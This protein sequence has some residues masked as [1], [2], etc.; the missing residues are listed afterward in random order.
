[1]KR[2]TVLALLCTAVLH[3]AYTQ[4]FELSGGG[5]TILFDTFHETLKHRIMLPE[6]YRG[7][8]NLGQ[9]S[10][11]A[12]FE[13]SLQLTG[14]NSNAGG[15][16]LAGSRPGAMLR[17]E[18]RREEAISGG[19]RHILTL[20]LPDGSLKVESYYEFYDGASTV[21]RYT[22]VTNTGKEP[23]GIEFLSSAVLHNIGVPGHLPLNDKLTFFRGDNGWKAEGRWLELSP[24]QMGYGSSGQFQR[25][26]ATITNTGSMSTVAFLPMGV[27]RD[28]E[29]G[30][31][32]F[33]QIEHNGSWHWEFS[34][35]NA[36]GLN[37]NGH[38]QAP[39]YMY[40]GGPDETRHA[41][42]KALAP[43]EV[44]TSIPV[45][46]GCV[47]GSFEE[48][49]AALTRYRRAACITPHSDNAKVPVI[50]NDYMNCLWADP[51]TEKEIPLI[52]AAAKAGCDYFVIDAGWYAETGKPWWSEVGEWMPSK[53]RWEPG[54][55]TA[56]LEMIRQKGMIPG[57]WLEIER[58][59]IH[60]PL[61]S[62][63]DAWFFTRHGKRVVISDSYQ[64]DF[65]NP[66][67]RKFADEVI[68]R[69]VGQY[70]VGYIKMD[71]NIQSGLGSERG[72]VSAGQGLLRHNRAY[73]AWL[74]EVYRRY[75]NL[76][77]ENCGSGGCRMDYA[78]LSLHQIQSSSDQSDYRKYPAILAGAMAAVLPEQLAAWSY[79][80]PEGDADEAAFNMVSAM[81]GRIHQ[82][83]HL[84][85]LP[86]ANFVQVQ[87][88]IEVY[89]RYLA[90][91]TSKSFPFYPLGL[92][93][94]TDNIS[95]VALGIRDGATEFIAVWRLSG[96]ETVKIEAGGD[97]ELLYPTDLGVTLFRGQGCFSVELPRPNMACIL[98]ITR[99]K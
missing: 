93:Q 16:K 51:T 35:V 92:P 11:E 37:P 36:P 26:A 87:K 17:L 18:G 67:V 56:V 61:A 58:V 6:G 66:E 27:V 28:R 7:D 73:L 64:L 78:M 12:E 1:M 80:L 62:K 30:L 3:Q 4:S 2:Y 32:W 69:V 5:L 19:K 72:E 48:A 98:K 96:P 91:H 55:L 22:Q 45:A 94:I 10:R 20:T 44:Y 15:S 68:D 38:N 9:M 84:A 33:W 13:V 46:V 75:P 21:R 97:V 47:E 23:V 89:K 54:G 57:L 40:I 49:V 83:G 34:D 52:E 14:H 74:K 76:V 65:S 88:G 42:W 59:G 81:M 43:G 25:S 79:P 85:N 63:P 86:A 99:N 50:F 53:T 70:K 77:I 8:V 31:S 90:P 39:T 71:Y 95:P 41:A 60:S 29:L 82:S 24:L